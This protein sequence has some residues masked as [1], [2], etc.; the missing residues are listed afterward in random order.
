MEV[1]T[2]ILDGRT[3]DM[4]IETINLS[5]KGEFVST[6]QVER[7]P[8]KTSPPLKT[9]QRV[10]IDPQITTFEPFDRFHCLRD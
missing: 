8:L 10:L 2:H 3:K 7:A 9:T 1:P 4:A 5:M 6:S